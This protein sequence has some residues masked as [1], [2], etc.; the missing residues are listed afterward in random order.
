M[1]K[2]N[3]FLP[4]CS[5]LASRSVC[6]IGVVDT[7]NNFFRFSRQTKDNGSLWLCLFLQIIGCTGPEGGGSRAGNTVR[8][9]VHEEDIPLG[10]RSVNQLNFILEY[11]G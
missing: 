1:A 2:G 3:C 11:K 10:D 6:L 5:T 4:A 7:G 9:V 8:M